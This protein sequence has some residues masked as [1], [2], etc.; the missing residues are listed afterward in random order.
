[1]GT[2]TKAKVIMPMICD[3]GGNNPTGGFAVESVEDV[4]ATNGTVAL[5]A[6][7]VLAVRTSAVERGNSVVSASAI[8]NVVGCVSSGVTHQSI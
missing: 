7:I 5:P 4:K 2:S 3:E 6:G 1:M 8:A